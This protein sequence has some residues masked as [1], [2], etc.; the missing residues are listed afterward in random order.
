METETTENSHLVKAMQEYEADKKIY[1]KI[2]SIYDFY[3][4]PYIA[5]IAK[6]VIKHYDFTPEYFFTV[7]TQKREVVDARYFFCYIIRKIY[8]SD[9][10][11][12][13]IGKCFD[14]DH[15]TMVHGF[16]QLEVLTLNNRHY[17][18]TYSTLLDDDNIGELILKKK[19]GSNMYYNANIRNVV[20]DIEEILK[21]NIKVN[22]N[23]VEP[24]A[25]GIKE[26]A[27]EIK[28]YFKRIVKINK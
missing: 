15:A 11:Y 20:L 3:T 7:K 16:N 4:A 1:P 8:G 13:S 10:S 28:N 24:Y 9:I 14:K 5:K 17:G 27:E 12:E 22:T 25:M 2:Y 23:T 21:A 26:S 6:A 18:E 19:I